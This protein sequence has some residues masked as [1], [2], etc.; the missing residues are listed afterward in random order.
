MLG[1][2][3]DR[4]PSLLLVVPLIV[5]AALAVTGWWLLAGGG[6]QPAAPATPSGPAAEAAPF[7]LPASQLGTGLEPGAGGIRA[8]PVAE[9]HSL[10]T[11]SAEAVVTRS[12]TAGAAA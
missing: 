7:L 5:V 2:Y 12:W 3:R 9:I 4:S 11:A 6:D 1:M 8:T 10:G